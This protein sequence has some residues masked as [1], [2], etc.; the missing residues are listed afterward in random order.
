MPDPRG[1]ILYIHPSKLPVDQPVDWS[2]GASPYLIAPMGIVGLANLLRERG[3]EVVGLNYPME[4]AVDPTFRLVPWLREQAGVRLVMIDLHWYEHSYGAMDVMRACKHVWPDVPVLLGG[5]TASRFYEEIMANFNAVDYVVRGDPELPMIAL[6]DG[7]PLANIPNLS[8]RLDGQPVHN[9]RLYHGTVGDLEA[10]D[11]VDTSFFVHADHYAEFQSSDFGRL[12]GQ[13]LCVGRG[14]HFNC[15]YCGGA[16]QSHL[17]VAGRE[18]IM[19]RRPELV[20]RD[21]DRLAERRLDQVS[22]SH[23]PAILGKPYWSRLFDVVRERGTKIGIYN[24]CWQLPTVEWVDALADTFVVPDSQLAISPLSGNEAVRR[25]NGKFYGNDRLFQFLDA[26]ERRK[27]PIFVYFSLNLPG[28]T[29]VTLQDTIALARRIV[30]SYPPELITVA[31]MHH[32]IDPESAFALQPDRFNITVQMKTFMHY[33][34]YCY[35]TPYARPEAK[36]GRVRGFE[37]EPP[38]SRS[39]ARMA[40][41]W[42]TLAAELAPVVKPVPAV[43]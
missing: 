13:W 17:N 11:F 8:Y 6:A 31:N 4:V 40:H 38:E 42:D 23:D 25:L 24:E 10:L 2:R 39:L 15:G 7:A 20:A 30:E 34:E 33:Y 3:H 26:L 41:A 21:V 35:L 43:W 27:V 9:D 28:E 29:D 19:V 32:T 22:L 37:M 12:K 1:R 36:V 14:C 18:A 16:R 5:M